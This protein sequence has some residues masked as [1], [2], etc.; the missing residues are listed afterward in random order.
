MIELDLHSRLPIYE[1][2]KN[3]ICELALL[4]EL[5]PND[6]LP[7]VR[8]FARDLGVNPN[9]VQKAYQELERE[10]IIVS[11]TGKG[12]FLSGSFQLEL[13]LRG[14]FIKKVA[15]LA[16]QAKQSGISADH[17][18]EAVRRVYEEGYTA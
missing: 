13:H 15:Q 18:L 8:S 16:M 2:L 14:Q 7:S 9:T 11:V 1:Q 5:K 6:Q 3:K 17:L 4:G 10:G 12:S